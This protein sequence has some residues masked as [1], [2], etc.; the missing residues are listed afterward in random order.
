MFFDFIKCQGNGI[1]TYW[2][3][4]FLQMAAH[5]WFSILQSSERQKREN[6]TEWCVRWSNSKE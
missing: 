6:W 2:N 5:A 1:T 3:T 4:F